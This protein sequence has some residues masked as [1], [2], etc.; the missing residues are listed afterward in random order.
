MTDFY[1]K[2]LAESNGGRILKI[3]QYLA[4]LLTKNVVVLLTHTVHVHFD[5]SLNSNKDDW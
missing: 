5:E 3:D 1:C 2:C 4:K